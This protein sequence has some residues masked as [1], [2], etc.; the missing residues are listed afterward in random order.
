MFS[1]GFLFHSLLQQRVCSWGLPDRRLAHHHSPC[2]FIRA[3]ACMCVCVCV[4]VRAR[5]RAHALTLAQEATL[6]ELWGFCLAGWLVGLVFL[7]FQDRV[8][9]GCPG[10]TL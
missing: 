8:S 10:T 7:A 1:R 5:V 3:H 2:F 6:Q 9:P 4:C